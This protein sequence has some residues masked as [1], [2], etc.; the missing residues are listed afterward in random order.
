MPTHHQEDHQASPGKSPQAEPLILRVEQ[1]ASRR[2][3]RVARKNEP[4]STRRVLQYG[5]TEGCR[6][7]IVTNLLSTNTTDHM[8]TYRGDPYHPNNQTNRAGQGK[9]GKNDERR[10]KKGRREETPW[11]RAE[12]R[13]HE[14]YRTIAFAPVRPAHS[15]RPAPVW[16]RK[17][18]NWRCW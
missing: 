7:F 9:E 1:S 14:G 5:L 18:R 10:E 15:T 13:V 3:E 4:R 11:D 8:Y 16:E 17:K 2:G 12:I 6:L